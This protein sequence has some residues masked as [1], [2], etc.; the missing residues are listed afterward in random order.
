MKKHAGVTL[1]PC[2]TDISPDSDSD[3]DGVDGV[4]ARDVWN[5][6]LSEAT[7]A[8]S[9]QSD[10]CR[11]FIDVDA[12]LSTHDDASRCELTDRTG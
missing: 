5:Y 4:E 8:R 7:A 1:W 2:D 3:D 11:V 12:V 10:S 6:S 9:R